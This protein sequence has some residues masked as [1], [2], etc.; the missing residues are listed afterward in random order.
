M[1][2]QETIDLIRE[3]DIAELVSKYVPGGLTVKGHKATA[4]CPLP[5]HNEKTPSFHVD[6]RRQ[7]YKCFGCGKGG[8]GISFIMEMEKCDFYA[9]L[10]SIAQSFSIQLEYTAETRESAAPRET[11][12]K[13][14]HEVAKIYRQQLDALPE[15]GPVRSYLQDRG[16]GT[17]DVLQWHIG[18][19][20][21]KKPL[22]KL[23]REGKNYQAGLDLGLI[24]QLSSGNTVD[25]FYNRIMFPIQDLNGR[26]V[27]FTGRV[28]PSEATPKTPK[29]VN[30]KESDIF[31]KSKVL[32]GLNQATQGIKDAKG[33]CYLVEGQTDVI[34]WHQ[35]GIT[36]TIATSGTALTESQAKLI[37]R[38]ASTVVLARDGD[39][40][41]VSAAMKD[42]NTLLAQKLSVKVVE[43][44]K[45]K[46]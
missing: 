6:T 19:A 4:C 28:L 30:S 14:N 46:K 9:A 22:S 44:K 8:D 31:K 18:W 36:N 13:I 27:G 15:D 25:T 33:R 41:G 1:I 37:K 3:V 39:Q 20:D 45:E 34:S 42:I 2:K 35:F 16:Y 29:Y 23:F 43:L 24:K 11:L 21:D 32:F 5:D 17:D 7:Y 40:A 26:I 38:Y 10:N 12:F